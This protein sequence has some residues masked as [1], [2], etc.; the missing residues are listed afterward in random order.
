MRVVPKARKQFILDPVK[1]KRVQKLLKARSETE[2]VER[3]LED[4]LVGEEIA[5]RLKRM[6]GKFQ[7][8]NMDQS[9]FVE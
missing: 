9:T 4:L 8:E 5:R 1:I 3:A 7:I 6:A 2:A